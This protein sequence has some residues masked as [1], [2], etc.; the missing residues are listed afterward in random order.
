[1][2]I[3]GVVAEIRFAPD[4]PLAKRGII[5][6]QNLMRGLVPV[7][8]LGLLAPETIGVFNGAAMEF[9]V[10]AHALP[11]VWRLGYDEIMAVG[12]KV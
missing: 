11:P 9:F 8:H 6:L 7:D 3:H 1:V 5:V 10:T 12:M 4:K 2:P